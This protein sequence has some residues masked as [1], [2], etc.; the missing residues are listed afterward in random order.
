MT[1][2]PAPIDPPMDPAA[3]SRSPAWGG[4]LALALAPWMIC[5]ICAGFARVLTRGLGSLY[6]LMQ[7]RWL[8][9]AQGGVALAALGALAL[10]R[11][12]R[13]LYLPDWTVWALAAATL[14]LCY[15]GHYACARRL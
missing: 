13:A 2:A 15:G 6:F 3:P 12:R 10:P 14:A 8:L 11:L 5:A 1:I 4:V 9:I 7:D